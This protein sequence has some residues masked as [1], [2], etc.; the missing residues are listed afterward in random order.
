MGKSNA[1]RLHVCHLASGGYLLT[2]VGRHS[3][4]DACPGP[5]NPSVTEKDFWKPL[6]NVPVRHRLDNISI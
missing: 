2:L 5:V 4:S 3:H 1:G 6:L